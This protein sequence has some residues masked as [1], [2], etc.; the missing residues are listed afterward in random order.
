M[1]QQLLEFFKSECSAYAVVS[2]GNWLRILLQIIW[3]SSPSVFIALAYYYEARVIALGFLLWGYITLILLNQYKMA[4]LNKVLNSKE[5]TFSWNPGTAGRRLRKHQKI[6]LLAKINECVTMK[7]SD[8][9]LDQYK[10]IREEFIKDTAPTKQ[11]I[12][13]A[14]TFIAGLAVGA[15][16]L[17]HSQFINSLNGVLFAHIL[18]FAL[19][20]AIVVAVIFGVDIFNWLTNG[21]ESNKDAIIKIISEEIDALLLKTKKED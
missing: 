3:I 21:A 6:L 19:T 15:F 14:K 9:K 16:F 10:D 5:K 4:R 12:A 18:Y 13:T 17:Y 20:L 7:Y 1:Q 2:N 11:D 8:N